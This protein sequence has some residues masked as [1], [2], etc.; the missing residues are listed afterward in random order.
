LGNGRRSKTNLRREEQQLSSRN[1]ADKKPG[2]GMA[3][4]S[5][6]PVALPALTRVTIEFDAR[7]DRI[8]LTGQLNDGEAVRLWL[9]RRMAIL[10]LPRLLEG[11]EQEVPSSVAAEAIQEFRQQ[12]AIAA[13]RAEPQAPVRA[14]PEAREWLVTTVDV[15]RQRNQV[16]LVFKGDDP[17]D[18][19]SLTLQPGP[20]RQWLGAI[21][22]QFQ[23]GQW[24]TDIWPAWMLEAA[25]PAASGDA[26]KLLN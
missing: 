20:M 14:G 7:E 1:P 10:F 2:A 11:L 3:P 26:K 9:T 23:L 5:D 22:S 16:K 12:G 15:S 6:K 21:L 17:G 18:S 4:A 25:K 19:V 8:R 24:P 13:L